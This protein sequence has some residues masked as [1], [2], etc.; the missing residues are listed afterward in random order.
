[1]KEIFKCIQKLIVI[2]KVI[3]VLEIMICFV[4]WKYP[5]EAPALRTLLEIFDQHLSIV[6]C[7]VSQ[8]AVEIGVPTEY[9]LWKSETE[10]FRIHS[11]MLKE[12]K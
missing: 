10:K 7:D 3:E 2:R 9:S 8:N 6:C 1:M 12:F 11:K 4:C 5:G